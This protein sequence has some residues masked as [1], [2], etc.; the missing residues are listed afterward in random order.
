MTA[1]AL[2][3]QPW[4]ACLCKCPPLLAV[5][6]TAA[7]DG[8]LAMRL[9]SSASL[10]SATRAYD[11][12]RLRPHSRF[13]P[14]YERQLCAQSAANYTRA[15]VRRARAAARTLRERTILHT[16]TGTR[17]IYSTAAPVPAPVPVPVGAGAGTGRTG[18][19]GA[20]VTEI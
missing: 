16:G 8:R 13:L 19:V 14:M 3:A 2:T 11:F 7:A 5:D 20:C 6:L 17:R 12:A 15:C 18:P 4:L 1:R 9:A 10:H